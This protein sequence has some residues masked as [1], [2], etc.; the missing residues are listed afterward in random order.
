MFDFTFLLSGLQCCL[1]RVGPIMNATFCGVFFFSPLPQTLCYM[2]KCNVSSAHDGK[3]M[4]IFYF[5]SI[6]LAVFL[7]DGPQ[8]GP[9]F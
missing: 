8:I 4:V 6:D 1:T 5:T 3:P 7:I 9:Q 2:D